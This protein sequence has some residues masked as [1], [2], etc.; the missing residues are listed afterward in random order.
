M[1]GF[2]RLLSSGPLRWDLGWLESRGDGEM[3]MGTKKGELIEVGQLWTQ[4]QFIHFP[5]V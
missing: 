5:Q 4:S 2:R 1:G 3:L